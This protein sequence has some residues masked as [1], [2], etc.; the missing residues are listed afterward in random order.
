MLNCP[1]F[2][3][4]YHVEAIEPDKVLF[5]SE[6]EV[7]WLDDSLHSLIASLVN[8]DRTTEEIFALLQQQLSQG[9]ILSEDPTTFQKILDISL[10]IQRALFE[11]ERQGYLVEQSQQLSSQTNIFCNHLNIPP[12]LAYQRLQSIQVTVKAIGSVPTEG[13]ITLLNSL[14][15]QVASE[16]DLTVVLVEDYLQP[17][18][19]KLNE[20][21]LRSRST[22]ML[23]KP[24]GTVGW[25]G[26]LL[27]PDKTGCWQCLASRLEDNRPVEGFIQRAKGSRD[28]LS[29]PLGFVPSTVQTILGMAATE[30][31][32]WIVQGENPQIEGTLLTYDTL[33]LQTREHTLVRRPQCSSCGNP[34][35][36]TRALPV[37]I[38]HRQKGYIAD[39]GHRTCFPEETLR[40]YQHHISPITGVVRELNKLPGHNLLHTYM[41]KHPFRTIFDDLDNLARN[42]GGR[43]AGK[44]RTDAQ[45]RASGFC[46]AIER[47]SGVFQG[48]EA[49]EKGSYVQMGDR[50]ID[51]N[52]CMLFSEQQYQT[53]EAWNARNQGWFQK[54]PEPFD[55]ERE[56]EW[57]PVWSLTHQAFK[58]LPTAYCY[59]GYAPGYNPDCWADS[60]GC[61]A[62]NTIEEA[63]LQGFMELVERDS[64]A[65]WWYNRLRKPQVDLGSFGEPY[66]ERLQQYYQS[67]D[68]ELWV[69]DIT[70]DLNIPTFA[71]ITC[72]KDQ[73]SKDIVLG[74]GTH[75]DPLIALSRSLTEVNQIL[76]N[77]LTEADGKTSYSPN[78]DPLAI[79]WWE[80]ATLANQIYLSPNPDALVKRRDDYAPLASDDLFK[81]VKLCQKIV[82][83]RGM[84]ML[85]LD[86]TR[87]DVGLR[88]AKVI[89][90]GLRHMWRRLGPG[91]LYEVPIQA[92]WLSAS[93]QEDE[94]NAFPMW[95]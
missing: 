62:G 27:V 18:L 8:G 66:F 9:Q 5:L 71:A 65:L 45:A 70:S 53:R 38:G 33:M 74:Y 22:W 42:L 17:E 29:A 50:A 30:V 40:K 37:A 72:R 15:V 19:L 69:L 48:N 6:R 13:F 93:L 14:S 36:L 83:D 21:M 47:Y 56:I 44:G 59:Y 73:G 51:P 79:Q 3:P 34:D 77:V 43:S 49:R 68:R 57:T 64:V 67:L 39:G 28:R 75:F 12:D 54:V 76:P 16:G 92:N 24:W 87:P 35:S 85:V 86:Q 63:I 41:A 11:M 31:F 32:K 1:N 61:A 23:V 25:I 26:P 10:R 89:V 78:A 82:E 4:C 2:K 84:E 52:A 46:E 7:S 60:N 55:P 20:H 90:P 91:R 80:T 94:L 58:Y 81:D 88:V 95:M